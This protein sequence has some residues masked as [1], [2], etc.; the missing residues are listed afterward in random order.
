MFKNILV[1]L[2]V[3]FFVWLIAVPVV[4]IFNEWGSFFPW[5]DNTTADISYS[6]MFHKSY[7]GV[8]NIL[9]SIF[10]AVILLLLIVGPPIAGIML[11]FFILLS[12]D[13]VTDLIKFIKVKYKEYEDEIS[14]D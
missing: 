7:S 5:L 8:V 9:A 3:L 1:V 4:Y 12:S 2:I 11:L 14:N 10:A 13:K 6:E